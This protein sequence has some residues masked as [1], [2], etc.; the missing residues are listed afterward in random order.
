MNLVTRTPID[1][2]NL[3]FRA[4]HPKAGAMLL[5]CGDVRNHSNG[6]EVIALEYEAHETMAL[7]QI[8]DIV[9]EAQQRWE[10]HFVEVIHRFGKMGIS[11]C[12]IAIAV[13]TSHRSDAYAASRYLI[14]TVKHTVPIWKK[15]CFQ[16]GTEEW[17]KGCE[18]CGVHEHSPESMADQHVPNQQSSISSM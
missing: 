8:D 1:L 3:R 5:F 16:N 7:K 6:K 18:A 11:E 9:K 12:S 17:S 2:E 15:E 13:A 4:H 14:D 10:L